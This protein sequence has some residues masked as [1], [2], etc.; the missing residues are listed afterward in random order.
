MNTTKIDAEVDW[1]SARSYETAL[2][3]TEKIPPPLNS[4]YDINSDDKKRKKHSKSKKNKKH[5]ESHNDQK[6][7]LRM[8][9]TKEHTDSDFSD[10]ENEELENKR[11]IPYGHELIYLPNGN[12]IV[13]TTHESRNHCHVSDDWRVDRI[14]DDDMRIFQGSYRLDVPDYELTEGHRKI[15]SNTLAKQSANSAL[16]KTGITS[17]NDSVTR[18]RYFG[19]D[20]SASMSLKRWRK[21]SSLSL[22]SYVLGGMGLVPLP[23]LTAVTEASETYCSDS[24]VCEAEAMALNKCLTHRTRESDGVEKVRAW[25]ELAASQGKLVNLQRYAAGAAVSGKSAIRARDKVVME[26]QAAVLEDGIRSTTEG[27]DLLYSALLRLSSVNADAETSLLLWDRAVKACPL[28]YLLRFGQLAFARTAFLNISDCSV[29]S[30]RRALTAG[31]KDVIRDTRNEA[32]ALRLSELMMGARGGG[33]GAGLAEWNA[34]QVDVW[35]EQLVA[36]TAAGFTERTVALVQAILELN[37]FGATEG[38]DSDEAAGLLALASWWEQEGPRVGEA[39]RASGPWLDMESLFVLPSP[40]PLEGP[41]S[42]SEPSED[43]PIASAHRQSQLDPIGQGHVPE[44]QKAK[45]TSGS[46]ANATDGEDELVYSRIHG[47]R[48][49]MSERDSGLVYKKILGGLTDIGG[50]EAVELSAEEILKK[51]APVPK[52]VPPMPAVGDVFLS[53]WR[54]EVVASKCQWRPLRALAQEDFELAE[55]QPDRVILAEDLQEQLYRFDKQSTARIVVRSLQKLGISLPYFQGTDGL[56]HRTAPLTLPSFGMWPTLPRLW[57]RA[58]DDRFLQSPGLTVRALVPNDLLELVAPL[59]PLAASE[60]LLDC[61]RQGLSRDSGERGSLVDF[62]IRLTDQLASA[63]SGLRSSLRAGTLW[64]LAQKFLALKGVGG[65]ET[66]AAALTVRDFCRDLVQRW[67]EDSGA[68]D[69]RVWTGLVAVETVVGSQKDALKV[70]LKSLK[71]MYGSLVPADKSDE[72]DFARRVS[73]VKGGLELVWTAVRM[74]LGLALVEGDESMHQS[75]A[76]NSPIEALE[77]ALQVTRLS[78]SKKSKGKAVAPVE[79]AALGLQ[80]GALL[81]LALSLFQEAESRTEGDGGEDEIDMT[82]TFYFAAT[83]AAWAA[84]LVT[85]VH[86]PQGAHRGDAVSAADFVFQSFLG[87]SDCGAPQGLTMYT[88]GPRANS[89][90]P[91]RFQTNR[92]TRLALGLERL[93]VARIELLL[94]ARQTSLLGDFGVRRVQ[95][96]LSEA[97]HQFPQNYQLLSTMI[98]LE[99]ELPGGYLRAKAYFKALPS[100]SDRFSLGVSCIERLAEVCLEII[101]A[102]KVSVGPE[103]MLREWTDDD[104]ARVIGVLDAAHQDPFLRSAPAFW[105]LYASLEQKRGRFEDARKSI[106]RGT[107][108]CWWSKDVWLFALGPLRRCFSVTELRSVLSVIEAKGL[109]IRTEG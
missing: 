71:A 75:G 9:K 17:D 7:T 12:V 52:Y 97:L 5:K 28:S 54:R 76:A 88:G 102:D 31:V 73:G 13:A 65:V 104:H 74:H 106:L 62:A 40:L 38:S 55:A 94:Y 44:E 6:E 101:R 82:P 53:R 64:L 56:S 19:R 11:L 80:K 78:S 24:Q 43:S 18:S 60:H 22:K 8:P 84:F 99:S 26:R 4:N 105:M 109:H 1:L 89:R 46:V 95:T 61:F 107:Q 16:K 30:G 32:A 35:T 66:V 96:A 90:T 58:L 103:S 57:A 92:G 42:A 83:L 100:R 27:L 86:D 14:P 72:T 36:E 108:S 3:K 23:P 39:G 49:R 15:S 70:C 50:E 25:L 29:T 91:D 67:Q 81:S 69:M 41:A 79:T 2:V 20:L 59:A 51:Y 98:A 85:A 48:I 47:Y 10:S 21:P 33:S 87:S 63:C 37:V 34:L 93:C 45:E 68:L 77:T